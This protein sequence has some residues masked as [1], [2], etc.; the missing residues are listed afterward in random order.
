MKK[1]LFDRFM[2][3][4]V[5]VHVSTQEQCTKFMKFLED[6][7]DKIWATGIKP[8]EFN[9]WSIYGADTL[10]YGDSV[11]SANRFNRLTFGDMQ[12]DYY[13]VIE[14]ED[15]MKEENNMK[16][17]VG[18]KVR[19]RSWDSMAKE[20]GVNRI[21]DICCDGMFLSKM[22]KFCEIVHTIKSVNNGF[23]YYSLEDDDYRFS[24]DMLEPVKEPTKEPTNGEN[25]RKELKVLKSN[26]CK[27]AIVDGKP[28]KCDWK[29]HCYECLFHDGNDC[30]KSLKKWCAEPY[31]EP[32]KPENKSVLDKEEHEF[33]QF[34]VDHI[35]PR[36]TSFRKCKIGYSKEKIFYYMENKEGECLPKFNNET[37]YAGM[38]PNKKYTLKE[39]GLE[40]KGE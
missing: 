27:V 10:I 32:E 29:I 4:K 30:L 9:D 20:F 39:L 6:N 26:G 37:M 33:L 31:E 5:A 13:P 23:K 21:G 25:F 38:E 18:D 15:L 22:K 35:S 8:T 16:F 28:T 14:F 40:K 7:T 12:N 24:G 3:G 11:Y 1:K 19:V 36:I 17:K 2:S 34:M